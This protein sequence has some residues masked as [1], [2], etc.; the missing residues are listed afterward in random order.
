MTVHMRALAA[1]LRLGLRLN[2]LRL[3]G[4]RHARLHITA[5]MH[6][7]PR[8]HLPMRARLRRRLGFRFLTARRFGLERARNS[9]R[10]ALGCLPFVHA[11]PLS[12]GFR[13]YVLYPN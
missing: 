4:R 10:L 9:L 7:R 8:M 13:L 5:R 11:L 12:R 3:L 6:M 1:L 2:L